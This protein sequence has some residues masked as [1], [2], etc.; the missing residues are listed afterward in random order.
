MGSQPFVASARRY[1]PR[2]WGSVLGQDATVRILQNAVR[3]KRIAHA[4]L[5]SGPRGTGKTS[6]ARL[7]AM[8]LNCEAMPAVIE[9]GGSIEPCGE[10]ESCRGIAES[11]DVDVL[12]IDA[13]SNRGIDDAKAIQKIAQQLMRPG[14]YRVVILDECH[15]LTSQAMNALLAL[16]EQPPSSFLPILCTTEPHSVLATIRSRCSCFTIRPLPSKAIQQSL[17]QIFADAKQPI[18][19]T[20][21]EALARISAGSL[22]DV[23]QVADQL[24]VCACGEPIGDDLLEAMGVPTVALFRRIAGALSVAWEEGPAVWFEEV[25]DL[26]SSGADLRLIF[27]TV[28]PCL[29]RDFRVVLVS[30]ERGGAQLVAYDSGIPHEM[31]LERSHFSHADLD[32]LTMAWEE[33]IKLFDLL[34]DRDALEFFFLKIWDQHRWV[35]QHGVT[36]G[37]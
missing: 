35:E 9:G 21:L 11:R 5:F 4:Y 28:I 31:L 1:R 32:T 2:K 22:R 37:V 27:F 34:T 19:A 10:C 6:L 17:A 25:E 30:R 24:I 3:L 20:A 26:W 7:L 12:E 15:Q 8:S 36:K 13:A 33:G 29:L 14:K 23:Q 18:E 16:F